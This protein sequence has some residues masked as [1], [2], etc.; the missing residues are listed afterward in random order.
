MGPQFGNDIEQLGDYSAR[1]I[2]CPIPSAHRSH[3]LGDGQGRKSLTGT[4]Y[5]MEPEAI[6]VEAVQR[7][8]TGHQPTESVKAG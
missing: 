1:S 6:K 5:G 2:P 3:R 4:P 7:P 8:T